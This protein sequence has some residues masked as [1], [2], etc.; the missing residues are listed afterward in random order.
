MARQIAWNDL[1]D[2]EELGESRT[3]VIEYE[4]TARGQIGIN[5]LRTHEGGMRVFRGHPTTRG[6][7]QTVTVG[8]AEL[9]WRGLQIIW[10]GQTLQ[11]DGD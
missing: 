2:P 4:F 7:Y 10:N 1:L 9:T 6:P 11:W 3:S 5:N 8:D